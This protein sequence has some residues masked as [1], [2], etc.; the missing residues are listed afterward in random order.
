[1]L[2]LPMFTTAQGG[3]MSH[4]ATFKTRTRSRALLAALACALLLAAVPAGASAIDPGA[5]PDGGIPLGQTQPSPSSRADGGIVL[6]HATTASPSA[7]D[8]GVSWG[9]FAGGGALLLLTLAGS[10]TAV[11][12]QRREGAVEATPA[13]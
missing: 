13:H 5:R 10:A 1:M 4:L 6:R 2:S 9:W 7:A 12:R 3:H 8:G 11:T